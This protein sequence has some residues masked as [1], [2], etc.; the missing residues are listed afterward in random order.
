MRLINNGQVGDVWFRLEAYP[1]QLILSIGNKSLL[2][3]GYPYS[4]IFFSSRE[5]FDELIHQLL[6]DLNKD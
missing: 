2:D 5:E 1:D 3:K 4:Q 6:E